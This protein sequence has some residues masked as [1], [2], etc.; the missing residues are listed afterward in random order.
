MSSQCR[1][2]LNSACDITNSTMQYRGV[3]VHDISCTKDRAG[4]DFQTAWWPIQAMSAFSNYHR[5]E[6]NTFEFE[7]Q[8]AL[9]TNATLKVAASLSLEDGLSVFRNP[10]EWVAESGQIDSKKSE[11]WSQNETHPF[12]WRRPL[13]NMG[14][15]YTMMLHCNTTGSLLSCF[16]ITA[17][18]LT[19]SQS[20]TSYIV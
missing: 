12:L 18:A 17:T 9:V 15:T 20:G 2:I 6:N 14:R 4:L 3:D 11:I 13:L 19:L 5:F 16:L 10:W 1:P 7:E 8:S